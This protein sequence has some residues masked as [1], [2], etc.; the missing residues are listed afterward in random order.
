MSA[1]RDTEVELVALV[2]ILRS[3]KHMV[4]VVTIGC[5]LAALAYALLATPIYRAEVIVTG[6]ADRGMG[7]PLSL[8]SQL[9]GIASFAGVNFGQSGSDREARAVLQSR[10]LV[11]E[12]IKRNELVTVLSPHAK[13]TPTMWNA[14]Q[15]FHESVLTIRDDIRR[16]VTTVSIEWT[17]PVTAAR[18]ANGF[19]ALANELIRSRA[20]EESK[21]N[22]AYL[23][24]QVSHTNV[25]ELQRVMY[26][27]IESETKTAMIANGRAEYAFR[28]VD[29]AVTPEIRAK[30]FR[31]LIILV[32]LTVGL[33]VG[34]AV[35]LTR[36]ALSRSNGG[37]L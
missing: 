21:R 26:S 15:R 13:K 8:A 7:G 36:T 28:V 23:N 19:V 33:L 32:G 17:D 27:L 1:D 35:A 10:R 34:V 20:L 25:V 2:K 3:H 11:E 18:W 22:I 4:A 30:P 12:F 14:V 5:G 9:S 6:V 29:P 31:A 24:E 16:G 37:S